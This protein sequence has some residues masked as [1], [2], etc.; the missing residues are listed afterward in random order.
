MSITEMKQELLERIEQA[1]DGQLVEMYGLLLN[2]KNGHDDE[3]SNWDDLPQWQQQ[4]ILKGLEEAES[5]LGTPLDVVNERLR[6]KYGL[7]E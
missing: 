7:S 3:A 1:N 5:G 4:A 6:N 2:Y